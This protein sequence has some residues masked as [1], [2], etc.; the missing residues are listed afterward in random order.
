[1]I[2]GGKVRKRKKK[3]SKQSREQYGLTP[4]SA[5]EEIP[6]KCR[7]VVGTG[8]Y[9]RLPVMDDVKLEAERRK[10]E[11]VVLPTTEAIQALKQAA[12]N[13]NVILH[14]IC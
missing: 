5:K 14:V 11:L 7:L 6:W 3:P 1:V 13:T 12:K 4:L 8:A 2:D 9:G 10:V